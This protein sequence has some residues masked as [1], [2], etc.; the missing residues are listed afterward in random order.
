MNTPNNASHGASRGLTAGLWASAAVLTALILIQ[1]GTLTGNAA[2]AEMVAH[3]GEFTAM[4]SDSGTEELLVV[5]DNRS[6]QLMVYRLRAQ[7]AL[8]LLQNLSVAKVFESARG[9]K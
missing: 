8:E 7:Q 5:L 1:A 9:G 6:E 4:T 3:A 2:R